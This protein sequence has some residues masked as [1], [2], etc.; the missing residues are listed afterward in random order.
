MSIGQRS[1]DSCSAMA[2]ELSHG[3][4]EG[5][6]GETFLNPA[7]SLISKRH[8]FPQSL[9]TSSGQGA[10]VHLSTSASTFVSTI[11]GAATYVINRSSSSNESPACTNS[12]QTSCP[13]TSSQ[14]HSFSTSY[15]LTSRPGNADTPGVS[16]SSNDQ[17]SPCTGTPNNGQ[18]RTH[19][20][21]ETKGGRREGVSKDASVSSMLESLRWEQECSDEEKEKERIK[22]YKANRR[23]RYEN[24]LEERKTQIITRAPYYAC[25]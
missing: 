16:S 4:C 3:S 1:T 14:R 6:G 2:M 25:R 7:L 19:G 10:T 24:A 9:N 12:E 20:V 21:C 22:E 23:K 18:E 15:T 13:S 5:Q 8:S 17:A 11:S